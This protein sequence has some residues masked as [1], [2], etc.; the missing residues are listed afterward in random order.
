VKTALQRLFVVVVLLLASLLLIFVLPQ[1]L[2][3][4]Q[5][6]EYPVP[7]DHR[8][9][10]ERIVTEGLVPANFDLVTA[11][12]ADDYINDTPLGP[13]DRAGLIG[14]I[15]ALHASLSNFEM[16]REIV[17]VEGDMG[18][19]RLVI[20]GVFDGEPFATP[21]GLLAPNGA[22]VEVVVHTIHRFNE[23]GLMAEEWAMFDVFGFLSQLGAF[24]AP[25]DAVM[26]PGVMTV[27]AA[28]QFAERFDAVF[29]GPSLEIADEIFAEDFVAHLPL[30][31]EL[32]RAG[33]KAYV[34]SFY[35]AMSDL[36]QEVNEVIV[37]GN[38]VIVRV[39]YTGT[40]DGP[41]FGIPATGN[42]VV[43]NAVGIFTFNDEG[44]AVE[45]WANLDVV[46]V[47]A[48]IGAFPPE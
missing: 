5:D 47:L 30:A 12:V 39:T 25:S 23:A 4:A 9:L 38:Q 37:S 36:T 17:M 46:G 3:S 27:E 8:E 15:Q 14:F 24:P 2:V 29:D 34:G 32:D 48:Q 43:M 11:W 35:A 22:A 19:T 45:N 6:S 10:L 16:E 21:L 40:H 13:L 26:Q 42:T 44:L 28:Q 1:T 18:A 20:R 31:P 33:W 41:L 7:A